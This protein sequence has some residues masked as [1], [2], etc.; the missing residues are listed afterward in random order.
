MNYDDDNYSNSNVK[1]KSRISSPPPGLFLETEYDRLTFLLGET[2]NPTW[3]AAFKPDLK[4]GVLRPYRVAQREAGLRLG[5]LDRLMPYSRQLMLTATTFLLRDLQETPPEGMSARHLARL[6]DFIITEQALIQVDFNVFP[7]PSSLPGFNELNF[8][9]QVEVLEAVIRLLDLAVTRKI[10]PDTHPLMERFIGRIDSLRA[11][12]KAR[13]VEEQRRQREEAQVGVQTWWPE[14]RLGNPV[15]TRPETAA[16]PVN[17]EIISPPFAPAAPPA[18]REHIKFKWENVWG[19]LLS[20]TT[21]RTL[22]YL[23]ALLVVAASAVFI[24][25]NWNQFPPFL[26]VTM[27][28]AVDLLFFAGGLAI[29]KVM[30]LARAGITFIAIG[31]AIL[32]F[33]LYGYTRPELLGLGGREAWLSVSLAAMACYLPLT[34]WLREKIFGYMTTLAA[35]NAF[36]TVLYQFQVAPE[37]I[38]ATSLLFATGLVV[39]SA[40]LQERPDL[41]ELAAPPFWVGQ[42]TVLT[43]TLGLF[44]Y[45]LYATFA[46][47]SFASLEYAMGTSWVLA[48]VF[49]AWCAYRHPAQRVIYTYG[50]SLAGLVVACLFLHKVPYVTNI[51]GLVLWVMGTGY[52]LAE[53][54][55]KLVEHLNENPDG[56]NLSPWRFQEIF[57]LKQPLTNFGWT[58]VLTSPLLAT[59]SFS[60][61]CYLGLVAAFLLGAAL[62][63]NWP[64]LAY[65]VV[66]VGAA[67]FYCLVAPA[68]DASRTGSWPWLSLLPVAA[69][70]LWQLALRRGSPRWDYFRKPFEITV[71]LGAA[72]TLLFTLYLYLNSNLKPGD[73]KNT[74]AASGLTRQ[75]AF[76]G[77]TVNLLLMAALYGMVAWFYRTRSRWSLDL[78]LALAVAAL[79]LAFPAT[80]NLTVALAGFG[81]ALAGYGLLEKAR[82]ELGRVYG[83]PMQQWGYGLATLGTL[84][85]F[86]NPHTSFQSRDNLTAA[87]TGGLYSLLA[88]ASTIAVPAGRLSWW[89]ELLHRFDSRILADRKNAYAGSFWLYPALGLIPCCLFEIWPGGWST[90]YFSLVLTGLSVAYFGLALLLRRLIP[91][92][93]GAVT[94]ESEKS[95]SIETRQF[96]RPVRGE[97]RPLKSHK[98]NR[99]PAVIYSFPALLAWFITGSIALMAASSYRLSSILAGLALAITCAVAAYVLK[100]WGF[101]YPVAL[102]GVWVAG[103]SLALSPL[104]YGGWLLTGAFT[105]VALAITGYRLGLDYGRPFR[106]TAH[107]AATFAALTALISTTF[108]R[109]PYWSLNT[110]NFQVATILVITALYVVLADRERH[111][112]FYAAMGL[113]A[114][115]VNAIV[116]TWTSGLAG[117]PLDYGLAWGFLFMAGI[118]AAWYFEVIRRLPQEP[119]FQ[120]KTARDRA[121]FRQL[122]KYPGS[123]SPKTRR[124]VWGRAEDTLSALAHLWSGLALLAALTGPDRFTLVGLGVIA[125][126]ATRSRLEERARLLVIPAILGFIVTL[127]AFRWANLDLHRAGLALVVLAAI[128]LGLGRLFEN[129]ALFGNNFNRH[130]AGLIFGYGGKALLVVAIGLAATNEPSLLVTLT[131]TALVGAWQAWKDRPEWS[132]LVAACCLS[133]YTL[134]FDLLN[135]GWQWF[136]LALFFPA[137]LI[138]AAGLFLQR[139]GNPG[140]KKVGHLIGLNSLWLIVLGL[141]FSWLA[142]PLFLAHTLAITVLCLFKVRTNGG[143]S[144]FYGLIVTGHLAYLAGL[145]TLFSNSPDTG[146]F[147][148][149]LV[150]LPPGL[151]IS[152]IA[153]WR[154]R[155]S[156]YHLLGLAARL[157]GLERVLFTESGFNFVALKEAFQPKEFTLYLAAGI[158]LVL[159]I[160]LTTGNHPAGLVTVVIVATWLVIMALWEGVETLV[161]LA[162]LPAVLAAWHSGFITGVEPDLATIYTAL[163]GF[164]LQALVYLS[165]RG[166]ARVLV[167]PAR[168]GAPALLTIATVTLAYLLVKNV[169][170]PDS[171]GYLSWLLSIIGLT[172]LM[173][174]IFEQRRRLSP[175]AY[176]RYLGYGSVALLE[177]AF[178]LWLILAGAVQLQVYAVPVGLLC[179]V[180]AWFERWHTNQRGASLL[181]GLGLLILLGTTLLQALGWQTGGP[182]KAWFG[183]LLL[184]E[185]ALAVAFG[186]ANRLRYYFFGGIAGVLLALAALLIDPVTAADRWLTIGGTGLV[187]IGVALLLER[188]REQI[189]R[190]AG[191]WLHRLEQW[192]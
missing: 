3:Q 66:L 180:F 156:G 133:A 102:L 18:R 11:A 75:A 83:R 17:T 42:L 41:A 191:E 74:G 146:L 107:L 15:E 72:A 187:L 120:G 70:I 186:A 84:E 142:G 101:N 68:F 99:G 98:T 45:S 172:F 143:V 178:V 73:F 91:G 51:Y 169:N 94:G 131:A 184:V 113:A 164:V 20:E 69:V 189:K 14:A 7:A 92:G 185:S 165:G 114:T 132:Y 157:K 110:N 135:P 154:S 13:V 43:T 60:L 81:L 137:G 140:H 118:T 10:V 117:W 149:G 147:K 37:W 34:W 124:F 80:Q 190:T 170:R 93:N 33:C 97:R 105:A 151:V 159:S 5:R 58:L 122:F 79:W 136:G 32:P 65:G 63:Y 27:L 4:E 82:A 78:G 130:Q 23:G 90:S 2:A 29:L 181:E 28:M 36:W 127:V 6:K 50:A 150:L 153:M 128:Y 168:F 163:A 35:L 115:L 88:V 16:Q 161:W 138:L 111:F 177:L 175:L 38:A 188:K 55:P 49:Y 167:R 182:D 176:L 54:L 123:S 108:T 87:I 121:G 44:S 46:G 61:A 67:G 22:L 57:N 171:W 173:V 59:S 155:A 19:A 47:T 174:S 125:L 116:A 30:K 109:Y 119:G 1:A 62:F 26:Q 100:Q 166:R 103:Q 25:L 158:D 89:P 53:T 106:Q 85:A 86:I 56:T 31:A 77:I 179:L 8:E 160:V 39:P 141:P 52:V 40:W 96:K 162:Y 64:V 21:L 112:L 71:H 24:T 139:T 9:M 95:K 145:A 126:Y 192:Q 148:A 144:W 48:T 12:E 104:P 152:A 76:D 183:T 129:K 134:G